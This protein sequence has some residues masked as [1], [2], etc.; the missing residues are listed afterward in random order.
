M[1]IK[2]QILFFI[3]VVLISCGKNSKLTELK[4]DEILVID[5]VE[6]GCFHY[7]HYIDSIKY[8]NEKY[9]VEEYELI[10]TTK[11]KIGFKSL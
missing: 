10:D 9:Y 7:Q 5:R 8:K 6:H 1:N 4:N 3:S 11:L 2:Y